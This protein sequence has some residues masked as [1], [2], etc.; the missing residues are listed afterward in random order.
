MKWVRLR[1]LLNGAI[2][3]AWR[4]SAR[5]AIT[6]LA[7]AI[8]AVAVVGFLAVSEGSRQQLYRQVDSLGTDLIIVSPG[9]GVLT[10]ED[11]GAL[12]DKKLAPAVGLVAP[13]VIMRGAVSSGDLE[14]AVTV[15]G[16]TPEYATIRSLTIRQG[17][18]LRERDVQSSALVG[19]LGSVAKGSLSAKVVRRGQMMFVENR[20]FALVGAL[21]PVAGTANSFL[22]NTVIVPIT[23]VQ[24][25]LA[26]GTSGGK[27]MPLSAINIQAVSPDSI[28]GAVEQIG[29]VIKARHGSVD[30]YV[31]TQETLAFKFR[32]VSNVLLFVLGAFAG[33]SILL[34]GVGM[35]NLML[36]SVAERRVEVGIRKS[37]GARDR[38]ILRQFVGEAM[39]LGALA[40]ALG[41]GV[42]W[43]AVPLF[44]RIEVAEQSFQPVVRGYVPLV[45]VGISVALGFISGLYPA[46][47]ASRIDPIEALR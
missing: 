18:F 30:F 3:V 44:D 26:A 40:G 29:K 10:V 21:D 5:S 24:F 7:V 19:I 37:V 17:R 38:D 16:T 34:A 27:D 23:T 32:E 45:T 39:V 41:A 6:L 14:T 43:A 47:R 8:S 36:S 2:I 12:L 20:P 13:E 22:D 15:L 9:T 1:I 33:A 25:L 46:Y 4:Y 35:T 31:E 11:A 42:G 28:N